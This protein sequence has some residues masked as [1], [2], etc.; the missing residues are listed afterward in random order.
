MDCSQVK[1][2]LADF[3]VEQLSPSQA[4]QL[5]EHCAQC[6]PCEGE[7]LLFQHT[8]LIASTTSQPLLSPRQ[9]QEI[10]HACAQSMMD[11]IERERLQKPQPSRG[12]SPFRLWARSQ[13]RWAWGAL[14]GAFAVLGGVWL[15]SPQDEGVNLPIPSQVNAG[16]MRFARPPAGASPLS[17]ITRRWHS[18]PSLITLAQR[19]C[20][21]RRRQRGRHLLLRRRAR[22]V[23]RAY[24]SRRCLN[25][26]RKLLSLHALNAFSIWLG[27]SGSRCPGCRAFFVEHA[28]DAR[29]APTA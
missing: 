17:T 26:G 16:L 5:L 12:R 15:L 7:R 21:L 28:A 25:S 18:I 4:Q 13:P 22:N 9:S 6:P 10:W 14:G 19:W 20:L 1:T 2:S 27:G 23:E 29:S 8:L 11:K 24:P 3:S